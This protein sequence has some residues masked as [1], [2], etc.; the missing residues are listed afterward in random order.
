MFFPFFRRSDYIGGGVWLD[1]CECNEVISHDKVHFME[2]WGSEW[3]IFCPFILIIFFF[4]YWYVIYVS[5][6]II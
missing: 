4:V 6:F 2:A 3:M 1:V 5:Q